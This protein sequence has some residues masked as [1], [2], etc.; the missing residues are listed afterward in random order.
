MKREYAIA[1]TYLEFMQWVRQDKASR[2]GVIF[3]NAAERCE[4]RKPSVLHRI[5]NWQESPA[6]PPAL[7]LEKV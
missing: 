1:G 2:S 7:R 3:L 6:F 5:G 4:G